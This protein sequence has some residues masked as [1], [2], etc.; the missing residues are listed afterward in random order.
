MSALSGKLRQF[1]ADRYPMPAIEEA[2]DHQATK[3]L[4]PHTGWLHIF[5]SLSL[6]AFLSQIITG[7]LLLIYYRPTAQ[8]AHKSIEYITGE[9]RFGWLYRQVHAWG[10]TLMI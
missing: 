5:G 1:F 3:R 4:P 8:E 9:V 6:M 2:I 10:A 7:I